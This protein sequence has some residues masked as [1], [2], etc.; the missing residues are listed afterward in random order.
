M[1]LQACINRERRAIKLVDREEKR[2]KAKMVTKIIVSVL[3]G[4]FVV[5]FLYL[6]QCLIGKPRRQ[7]LKLEKQRNQRAHHFIFVGKYP[8]KDIEALLTSSVC[9]KRSFGGYKA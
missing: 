8:S 9:S 2:G 4:G 7:R 1:N 5:V 3:F 6:Y